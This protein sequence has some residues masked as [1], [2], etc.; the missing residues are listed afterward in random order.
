MGC[1]AVF[2][3]FLLTNCSSD[4][5]ILGGNTTIETQK[6]PSQS[7]PPTDSHSERI[8]EN[9]PVLSGKIVYL[10]EVNG[11]EDVFIMDEDQ[12]NEIRLTSTSGSETHPHISA[13]RYKVCFSTRIAGIARPF[14]INSNGTGLIELPFLPG[15]NIS[16]MVW[17]PISHD[18]VFSSNA[19]GSFEVY[20]Y[21]IDS[22]ILTQLTNNNSSNWFSTWSPDGQKIIWSSNSSGTFKSYQMNADGS[23]QQPLINPTNLEERNP[24]FSPDGSKISFFGRPLTGGAWDMYLVD[25]DGSNL[26]RLTATNS[27]NEYHQTWSPD[28]R[29]LLFSA[30]TSNDEGLYLM[31]MQNNYSVQLF[32]DNNSIDEDD[33]HWK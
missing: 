1:V 27:I 29:F 5:S 3:V 18:I 24:E 10:K 15:A 14:M 32:L 19:T 20:K 6:S 17:S 31:D 8:N 22:D 30:Q 9:E 26:L 28:G 11:Q 2:C 33:P 13:D 21:N 4:R 23:N 16:H 7:S 25:A 12:T